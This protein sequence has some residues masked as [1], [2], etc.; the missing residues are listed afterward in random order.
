MMTK[1]VKKEPTLFR[2]IVSRSLISSLNE[3]VIISVFTPVMLLDAERNLLAIESGG[4]EREFELNS[5]H[6]IQVLR[7]DKKRGGVEYYQLNFVFNDGGRELV[8]CYTN[9][10]L[11]RKDLAVIAD[12]LGVKVWDASK[13]IDKEVNENG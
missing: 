8:R 11:M 7:K 10:A 2:K 12:F 6:A 1:L 4:E 5:V 3:E 9:P 13:M